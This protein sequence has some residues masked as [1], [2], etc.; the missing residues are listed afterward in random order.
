MIATNLLRQLLKLLQAGADEDRLRILRCACM[1]GLRA[2]A[3]GAGHGHPPTP[4]LATP[5][6]SAGCRPRR[7]PA[8]RQWVEYSLVDL[9]P[10]SLEARLLAL[11]LT[12]L[13][14]AFHPGRP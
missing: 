2:C 3:V 14:K 7:R 10:G 13:Q 6:H 4:G 11:T 12:V 9:A 1:Q 5:A 8:R